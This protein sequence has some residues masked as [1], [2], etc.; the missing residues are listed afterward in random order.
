M[1]DAIVQERALEFC[2]E[3]V[4]KA[5]LIRWNLLKTKL[6]E[7]KAKMYRLRDLQ[8]EYAELSGHLYYKMEDYNMDAQ[9]SIK[10]NR[11][12][13]SRNIRSEPR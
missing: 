13:Q 1:F 3:F 7:A 10:Y 5:D 4:R 6:D 8:G 12:W 2:G 11:R 9:R